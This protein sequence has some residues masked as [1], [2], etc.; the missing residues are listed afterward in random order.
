[1][2]NFGNRLSTAMKKIGM[3]KVQL[4]EVLN[5]TPTT[6]YRWEKGINET[7]DETK[8]KLAAILGVTVAYLMGE[9]ENP[10]QLNECPVAPQTDTGKL[11]DELAGRIASYYPDLA[12]LIYGDFSEAEIR[13][14]ASTLQAIAEMRAAISQS[15]PKIKDMDT[16]VS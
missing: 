12:K 4:A 1:M 16:K 15:Q 10:P 3:T 11:L 13:M 8:K 2:A 6:I 14:M 9:S 7:S 5:T